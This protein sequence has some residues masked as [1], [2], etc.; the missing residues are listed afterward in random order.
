[1]LTV[2]N[3]TKK[4]GT[5]TALQDINIQFENG[6]YGLLGPNGAGKTTLIKMLTTLMFPTKGEIL[7]KG[8]DITALDEEYRDK[9]G[10]LPQRFGFYKNYTPKQFLDYLG[11]LKGLEK[12]IL[13]SKVDELLELVALSDV[14]NKKM[15][16]FSGGMIQR[17]G[18][19]QAMLNDPKILILD[20]PT[21]GLDPKERV[22]FRNLISSL[23]QNRVVIFSTH[24]VSD[25]ESIA[26]KV[27]MFNDTK[28]L[29]NDSSSNI[30]KILEGKVFETSEVDKIGVPYFLLT[31]KQ[32]N[33]K[34]L[35]RFTSEEKPRCDVKRVAP[36]L[37]DVFLHIYKDEV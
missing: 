16:K 7:F 15:G 8:D 18:I 28:L 13:N 9:I 10:Y 11:T 24:I 29:Y 4:Y 1:M 31:E 27:I 20:E 32:E 14:A 19:A 12:S 6:V 3:V 17:V 21:T 30:C 5:F 34:S 33:G 26:N 36:N 2:R 25:I 37:E 22:R 35:I 23:S